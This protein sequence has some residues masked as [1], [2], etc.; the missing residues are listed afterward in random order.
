MNIK[1]LTIVGLCAVCLT[2]CSKKVMESGEMGNNTT[3]TMTNQSQSTPTIESNDFIEDLIGKMTIEEKVGQM[4]LYNGFYDATGPVPEGANNKE[5]YN[6]VKSGQVGAMLNVKNVKE[7]KALQKLAVDNS[8]LGIPMLFGFDVIHGHKISGPIPIAESASWD[9]EAIQ[10]AAA[11]AA[12]EAAAVGINWTFAPMVDIGRDAR[13][14][15]NM[16][17]AGEDPYLGSKIAAARVKG[18]QGDDL[19]DPNTIAACAKHFAGYGFAE[20]GKEYNTVDIGLSTMYNI[21]LPPF[22]A[23]VDAGVATFM[24]GFNEINGVPV[25]GDPWLQRDILKGEWG[26]QGFVVS[27]WGSI[28]EMVAHRYAKDNKT[29]AQIGANAGSDMDMESYVYIN[30]LKELIEEGAVKEATLDDAVRR[31]LKVKYDLGLFDDP[32]LYCD[33]DKEVRMADSQEVKDGVLD[34]AKKSIVLLKNE[35]VLPLSKNA[36][37]VAVIGQIASSKTSVLGSWRLG[38]A[39]NTAVSVIEGLE[40]YLGNNMKYERGVEVYSGPEVFAQEIQ[41]NEDNMDGID[42]AVR[43]A[44]SSDVVIVVA[45]EHGYQSGE[46]RSRADIRL[47]GLQREMLKKISEVNSNIVLVLTNGRPLDLSWEDAN[48]PAIVETWQLGAMSGHAI[49]S[50]LFGDHNPSGKLPMTFPHEVG[51]VPLYYNHKS[52]G[53][54]TPVDMVFWSHYSDV[55]NTGLCPTLHHRQVCKC[56]T[57]GERTQGI[58]K[59]LHRGW[60]IKDCQVYSDRCPPRLLQ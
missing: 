16:E 59:G 27:D 33:E 18:F 39:D 47:P 3:K 35:G 10:Q 23:A 29:A 12:M 11:Y 14:G 1:L 13:W 37:N 49:A 34:M 5:K 40:P 30:H 6:H 42:R 36:K 25:T 55:D 32:Y 51:Q 31:I 41:V 22:Q 48:I 44:K 46:G 50:V 9:L 19:S 15:R 43:L 26:F 2:C 20:A 24:N 52:T 53:R 21:V 57:S 28:G 38:A 7:I 60:W 56:Y 4:N 45:G 8:R 58:R 17:G 54:G